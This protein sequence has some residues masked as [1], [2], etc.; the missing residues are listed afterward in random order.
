VPKR[1]LTG[2]ETDALTSAAFENKHDGIDL[3]VGLLAYAGLRKA[4]VVAARWEWIDWNAKTLTVTQGDGFTTKSRRDR[5][6][7]LHS[8]LVA[9]LEPHQRPTGY[10]Y[11]PDKVGAGKYRV[12]FQ[13]PFRDVRM[14]AGLEWVTPH[15]LR[16]SWATNLIKAGAAVPKVS[17]WLG[18]SGIAIT[19]DIYSH[20]QG[21][22]ADIERL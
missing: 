15:L 10:I 4:E 12:D 18:H 3:V 22:D 9:I 11:A 20:L 13:R 1:T 6:L 14:A 5:A 19:A 21:Y 16:H 17:Q 2:Q 7:P 8:K